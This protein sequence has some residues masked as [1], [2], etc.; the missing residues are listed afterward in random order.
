M[1][2]QGLELRGQ[3]G[4]LLAQQQGRGLGPIQLPIGQGLF[5]IKISPGR[6]RRHQLQAPGRS[7]DQPLDQGRP[8]HPLHRQGQGR[9]RRGTQHLGLE[10]IGPLRQPEA[11]HP[12][13]Q[14]RAHQGAQVAG[15]LEAI[16]HQHK[17]LSIRWRLESSHGQ[18]EHYP[19]GMGRGGHRLQH[20]LPHGLDRD[21][22]R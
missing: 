17:R 8:V 16:E 19:I 2:G 18:G 14:G 12:G 11:I 6:H 1:A 7:R 5:A 22:R 4:A 21:R 10:G 9:P 3:A 20:L 13:R 15:V